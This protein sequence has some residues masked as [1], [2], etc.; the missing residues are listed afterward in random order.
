MTCE[1]CENI[2]KSIRS[3]S[4]LK[5]AIFL[6]KTKV[7]DETLKYL[8]SGYH[9]DPFSRISSGGGWGDFVSNYFSC[10]T[11]NQIIHLQAETYHGSGGSLNSI[12]EI[13]EKLEKDTYPK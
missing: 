9:G 10:N 1:S 7:L 11:C 2:R 6:V 5:A 8:G 13:E 3:P 4:D 12:S